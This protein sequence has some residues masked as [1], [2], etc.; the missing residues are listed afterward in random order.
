MVAASALARVVL[1]VPGTSSSS[2]WPSESRQI[3]ASRMTSG[4]PTSTSPIACTTASNRPANWA[5]SVASSTAGPEPFNACTWVPSS[6]MSTALIAWREPVLECR[7]PIPDGVGAAVPLVDGRVRLR[8]RA[9]GGVLRVPGTGG[10]AEQVHRVRRDD[11]HPGRA[12][13]VGAPLA[14]VLDRDAAGA[15][16]RRLRNGGEG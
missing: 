4:L 11:P 14:L 10:D 8:L 7:L 1:P 5:A 9:A 12:V 16:Q 3:S 6:C 15:G 13:G 2:R